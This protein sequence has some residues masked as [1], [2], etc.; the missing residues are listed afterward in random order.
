METCYY[1]L[2]FLLEDFWQLPVYNFDQVLDRPFYLHKMKA[3]ANLTVPFH[4]LTYSLLIPCI[5]AVLFQILLK[6]STL[7][8]ESFTWN[9]PTGNFYT[10]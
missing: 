4:D 1:L 2:R 6:S 9:P 3:V 8:V 7:D 5:L 10:F